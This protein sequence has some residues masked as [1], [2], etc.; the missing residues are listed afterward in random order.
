MRCRGGPVS[1]WVSVAMSRIL[2]THNTSPPGRLR[3]SF[4][5]S[6]RISKVIFQRSKRD[7]RGFPY[8]VAK[9][10]PPAT[11]S[12]STAQPQFS[13]VSVNQELFSAFFVISKR[14]T[15]T[16]SLRS[17]QETRRSIMGVRRS[18]RSFCAALLLTAVLACAATARTVA[19]EEA[20]E[21]TKPAP[22]AVDAAPVPAKE[23][24]PQ[25]PPARRATRGAA[26][27]V[28]GAA[29]QEEQPPK[30]PAAPEPQAAEPA[31]PEP[32][33]RAAKRGAA[34]LEEHAKKPAAAEDPVVPPHLR[35][36]DGSEECI[37][38]PRR[39][40]LRWFVGRGG[41]TFYAAGYC[42]KH[43][44]KDCD[45]PEFT[46]GSGATPF[47]TRTEKDAAKAAKCNTW[48][49]EDTRGAEL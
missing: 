47:W 28:D 15:T 42:N 22:E 9:S 25:A 37:A 33:R 32:K 39:G 31:K 23:E 27:G 16:L 44:R 30:E 41:E 34:A 12:C 26:S 18:G 2:E 1:A 8:V 36:M 19:A 3:K 10:V 4:P 11:D 45:T 48:A 49:W 43:Q 40:P 20:A 21:A 14:F 6:W 24:P 35:G 5:A 7:L 46:V 17:W 13:A 29:A 38:G